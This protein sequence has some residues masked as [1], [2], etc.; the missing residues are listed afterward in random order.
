MSTSH[1]ISVIM[2]G[3]LGK[4]M[5]TD[6]P[7][8][9][10]KVNDIP[11]IIHVLRKALLISSKYVVVVVGRYES[12]IKKCIDEYIDK[13]EI[14]K[15]KFIHQKEGVKNGE[16]HAKGTGDA[17]L[18]CMTFLEEQEK[19]AKVLVLS[20]DVP[21][22]TSK[23]LNE[24]ST[25]K[26]SLIISEARDPNGYGRVFIDADGS[27]TV[28]EHK[29]CKEN[30]LFYKY[31]NVGIY[32]FTIEFLSH[33]MIN[34]QVNSSGEIFLTDLPFQEFM[35]WRDFSLFTNVNTLEELQSL[36]HT[37]PSLKDAI[38]Y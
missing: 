26:N 13:S 38:I 6:T 2:A 12:D 16:P 14:S 35:F 5:K 1:I 25:F 11:M 17:L 20:G 7:K 29:F 4:R 24:F 21:M 9:L 30:M 22:I 27:I 10:C 18:S 19:D 36:N 8:V 34:L 37:T 23:L 3:G 31:V 32:M 28:R 33:H 15:I